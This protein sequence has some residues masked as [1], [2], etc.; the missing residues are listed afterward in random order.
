MK[1][2]GV[3]VL[4]NQ[5]SFIKYIIPYIKHNKY[6][7]FIIYNNSTDESLQ[8]L[9][10][11][12]LTFI[13]IRQFPNP[14]YKE[15]E[16]EIEKSRLFYTIFTE[17]KDEAEKTKETIWVQFSDFDEIIYTEEG[18]KQ[19]LSIINGYNIIPNNYN[20]LSRPCIN[21]YQPD[22]NNLQNIEFIHFSKGIKCFY[23]PYWGSKTTLI[24]VNDFKNNYP[25]FGIGMHT[26]KLICED[27]IIPKN[28]YEH[29]FIYY[30]HLKFLTEKDFIQNSKNS[31]LFQNDIN[32]LTNKF[33][34]AISTSFPLELYFYNEGINKGFKQSYLFDNYTLGDMSY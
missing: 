18:L 1:L 22:E 33:A 15:T 32:Y 3:T 20:Y 21:L 2:Y 31:Y 28:L 10:D 4:W 29:G 12:N 26:S 16:F 17:A 8:K 7:K 6:D 13:E 25:F 24:K 9:L 5:P 23:W 27:K 30:F 34:H 19:T 11:Y 14:H